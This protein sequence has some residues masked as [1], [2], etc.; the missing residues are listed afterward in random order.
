MHGRVISRLLSCAGIFSRVTLPFSIRVPFA[1]EL[2][3]VAR[4]LPQATSQQ[5]MRVAVI[6]RV[7]RIAAAAVLS[8]SE[9]PDDKAAFLRFAPC[10]NGTGVAMLPALLAELANEAFASGASRVRLVGSVAEDHPLYAGLLQ[11]GF[12]PYRQTELYRMGVA[13]LLKRVEPVYQKL[14]RRGLI[15]QTARVAAPQGAWLP[16]LRE[17]FEA[18]K[19]GLAERLEIE[20]EGFNPEHSFLLVLEDQIKGVFCTRNRGRESYVGLVLLAE[21]LRGG[22]AWANTFMMREMLTDGVG[23]GVERLVFEVHQADHRG[24]YQLA[25]ASEAERISR[26]W[27]FEKVFARNHEPGKLQ[28]LT[29]SAHQSQ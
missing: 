19:R 27:Q 1:D 5:A 24:T 14:V 21:E 12:E 8:L 6:G 15:P 22:L 11:Q 10:A 17:F 7:E 4:L 18:Q 28:P 25:R 29:S 23:S 13:A 16:K 26:R 3:R 9:S 2:P 20:A